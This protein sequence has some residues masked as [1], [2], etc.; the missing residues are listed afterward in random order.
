MIPTGRRLL[1]DQDARRVSPRAHGPGAVR[2]TRTQARATGCSMKIRSA[3]LKDQ[4]FTPSQI[5]ILDLPQIAVFGRS[6]VGKSSLLA[7]M[8]G[9][10]KLVRV[11]STPGKT[12]GIFFYSVNGQFLL[13][14]LPGYGFYKAPK[15]EAK[16]WQSLIEAYLDSPS[17]PSLAL[18]LIDI[19]HP[20]TR[21]DLVVSAI[22]SERGIPVVVVATKADK[23]SRA[24]RID[25]VNTISKALGI[26]SRRIVPASVKDPAISVTG[27][28]DAALPLFSPREEDTPKT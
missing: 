14:D 25:S 19:R 26:S 12:R 20:P 16:K 22:L 1:T 24:R 17:G 23:L 11:S 27:I 13:V 28:W 8:M 15:S 4:A 5:P 18:H 6:N 7:A 10:R 2:L 21:E 9:R 3:E